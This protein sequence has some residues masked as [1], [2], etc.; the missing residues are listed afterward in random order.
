M[1]EKEANYRGRLSKRT[2][3]ACQ[4]KGEYCGVFFLIDLY[5]IRRL[6]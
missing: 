5:I 6:C 1:K 4:M 2:R 3:T